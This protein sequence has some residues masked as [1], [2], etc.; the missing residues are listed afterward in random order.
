MELLLVLFVLFML[1]IVLPAIVIVGGF[2]VLHKPTRE[3]VRA[4]FGQGVTEQK[5]EQT[6][7]RQVVDTDKDDI[8][9]DYVDFMNQS[10][11]HV[12]DYAFVKIEKVR[13][14]AVRAE[15]KMIPLMNYD[16]PY[17][18]TPEEKNELNEQY[19]QFIIDHGYVEKIAETDEN[20]I[21]AVN[22]LINDMNDDVYKTFGRSVWD[23]SSVALQ[24]VFQSF[25]AD[26]QGEHSVSGIAAM[27]QVNKSEV[28]KT[29]DFADLKKIVEYGLSNEE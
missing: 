6:I 18:L 2:I 5:A 26:Y 20:N 11:L 21:F 9:Q 12:S 22:E 16:E 8:T 7:S 23:R 19:G 4:K 24:D 14:D 27:V 1:F 10:V 17:E 13:K 15:V 29:E 28:F 3:K 25:K